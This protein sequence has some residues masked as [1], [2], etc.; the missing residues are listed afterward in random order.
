M[1]FLLVLH[2]FFWILVIVFIKIINTE[3]KHVFQKMGKWKK[4]VFRKTVTQ[5][6]SGTLA[7]P[8]KNWKTETRDTST[9]LAEPYKNR[10]TQDPSEILGRPYK[11]RKTGAQDPSE[12][13]A[14]P[15]K[16]RKTGTWEPNGTLARPY[17]NRKTRALDPTRTLE[18]LFKGNNNFWFIFVLYFNLAF[19][20]SVKVFA[21]YRV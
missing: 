9:A 11:T 3:V 19:C 16:N 15:Y 21:V 1:L 12:I 2:F 20:S 6:P 18:N 5:D 13:L 4:L 8:Y 10:K 14:R 17:T 7:G